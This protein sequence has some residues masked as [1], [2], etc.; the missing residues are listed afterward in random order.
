MINLNQNQSSYAIELKLNSN[1]HLFSNS[2]KDKHS[3]LYYI[4]YMYHER[5]LEKELILHLAPHNHD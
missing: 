1:M 2:L 5:H 4:S 3:D